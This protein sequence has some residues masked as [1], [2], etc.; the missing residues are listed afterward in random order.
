MLPH[1]RARMAMTALTPRL[2]VRVRR[3]RRN[4]KRGL[5]E[6]DNRRAARVPAGRIW[7]CV[8]PALAIK[9][10]LA[11]AVVLTGLLIVFSDLI[12]TATTGTNS[13]SSSAAST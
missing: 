6:R 4:V 1:S 2:A 8:Q 12:A 9:P 10:V 3:H 7:P 5:D 11:I 13:T